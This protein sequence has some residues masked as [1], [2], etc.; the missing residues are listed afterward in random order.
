MKSLKL[1]C[2]LATNSNF[3]NSICFQP[4]VVRAFDISNYINKRLQRYKDFETEI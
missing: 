3:I 2:I 1:N 4:C